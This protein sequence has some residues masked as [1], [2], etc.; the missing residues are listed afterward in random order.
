M[1]AI[2]RE[3]AKPRWSVEHDLTTH[4]TLLRVCGMLN[5]A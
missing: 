4:E 3:G 2:I 5:P 1:A